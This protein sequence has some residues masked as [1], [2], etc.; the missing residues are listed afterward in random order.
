MKKYLLIAACLIMSVAL[1]HAQDVD[2]GGYLV[3]S[4]A[5]DVEDESPGFG[6]QGS[7]GIIEMCAAELSATWFSDSW[8]EEGMKFDGD[9]ST[10]AI[11]VLARKEVKD[12][13]T[14]YGG[15]GLNYNSFDISGP[16]VLE[17]LATEEGITVAQAQAQLDA[18]GGNITG[19]ISMDVDDNIGYL[20]CVGAEMVLTDRVELFGDF[21]YSVAEIEGTVSADYQI[22]I[23]GA[24]TW[25]GTMSEPITGGDYAFGLLRFGVKVNL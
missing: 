4:L 14:V 10:I 12:G 6:I 13:L 25:Q 2:V 1:C 23:G 8:T 5:G 7:V 21:R 16:S 3:Y 11:T 24:G 15:V 9:V 18:W 20:L 17:M 22:T 19:D